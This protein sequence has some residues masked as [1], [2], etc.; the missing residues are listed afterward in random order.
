VFNVENEPL[1][2]A[3]VA[4]PG[5]FEG[6]YGNKDVWA[7]VVRA[8]I[9]LTLLKVEPSHGSGLH[10]QSLRGS[11]WWL[12]SENHPRANLIGMVLESQPAWT[13]TNAVRSAGHCADESLMEIFRLRQ[14]GYKSL[15]LLEA[16]PG[17][18]PGCKDLQSSA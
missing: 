14:G 8:D 7:A 18:E 6:V 3:Q 2:G 5:H 13:T 10:L 15:I 9:A 12:L 4:Q 1:A 16:S 11:P 17:I